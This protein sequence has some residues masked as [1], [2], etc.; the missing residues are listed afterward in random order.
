MNAILNYAYG[1]LVSQMHIEAVAEGYDPRRGIMHH[2]R[3]AGDAFAWVFDVI[4]PRRAVV[5]GRVLKFVLSTTF[6]GADF[7]LS[8][9]G[10]C[11]L[12]PQLARRVAELV[13]D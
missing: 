6:S 10:V 11:R 9:D 2:D 12:T 7:A 8:S 5:D 3:D 1:M 13:S 4:E